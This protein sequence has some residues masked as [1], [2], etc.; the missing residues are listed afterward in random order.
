[1]NK[2]K[3]W[4]FI[5]WLF[6][7]Y[8]MIFFQWNKLS[9]VKRGLGVTWAAI[10]LISGISNG[11]AAQSPAAQQAAESAQTVKIQQAAESPPA[12]VESSTKI[13]YDATIQFPADRYP[14]TAKHIKAAISGGK[15]AV[16]TIDRA[17]AKENRSE[18]LTGMTTKEGYDRDEWPMAMCAEGGAGADVAYVESSDN[19]GAGSWVGHQLSEYPDGTRIRFVIANAEVKSADAKKKETAPAEKKPAA[20]KTPAAQP[21]LKKQPVKEEMPIVKEEPSSDVFYQNCSAVREAGMDPLY[22]GDPGYSTKLDRD[23]DGV[24]CE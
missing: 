12:A 20:P 13:G 18:A 9:G 23:R 5:G 21:E 2:K 1:M 17:G 8:I 19:R 11:Q 3:V 10:S 14:Q 22:E 6:I 24:A 7:P 16:C 15:E 4:K